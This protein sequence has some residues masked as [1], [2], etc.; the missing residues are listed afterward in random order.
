MNRKERFK[1]NRVQKIMLLF[2]AEKV[3]TSKFAT[4]KMLVVLRFMEELVAR[5]MVLSSIFVL[6]CLL[7]DKVGPTHLFC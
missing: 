2:P 3:M 7:V 6:E 5:L 4:K 1:T